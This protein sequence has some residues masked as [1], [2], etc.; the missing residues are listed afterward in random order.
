MNCE[1]E[2][3][4]VNDLG[5]AVRQSD[6]CVTCTPSRQ[7]FLKKEDVAAGTFIAAVGADNEE[8]QEIDPTLLAASKL[9]VDLVE[10]CATIGELHHALGK[11]VNDQGTGPCGTWGGYRRKESRAH[12]R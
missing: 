4:A 1:I 6:I 8:K 10:Q 9:V 2:V 7:Y 5:D 12:L 11:G 3:H